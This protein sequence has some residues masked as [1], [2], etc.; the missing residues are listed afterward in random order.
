MFA[1]KKHSSLRRLNTPDVFTGRPRSAGFTLIE[2]LVVIAIIA[3]L[4]AML[5]PALGRAKMRA[6]EAGCLN[7]GRQLM[8][9]WLMYYQDNEEKMMRAGPSGNLPGWVGGSMD[10]AAWNHPWDLADSVDTSQLIDSKNALIA[11]YVKSVGVFKCPAD[12]YQGPNNTA[13]RLRTYSINPGVGGKYGNIGGTYNPEDP[14]NPRNYIANTTDLKVQKLDRPGAAKVWVMVCEHP[15]SINDAILQFVPGC[16]PTSF[17]WQDMPGSLHNGG[18]TL[19][20]A[21]GHAE[22]HK[23]LDARTRWPVHMTF[24]WWQSGSGNY[25]VGIPTPSVDYAW[26]EQGIPYQ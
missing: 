23:W 17:T 21:D 2:L 19:S 11:Q 8:L 20:F 25:S 13:P 3:I 15:D 4:A 10:N 26:M 5:V 18:T 1:F 12:R 22:T 24:K 6:E 7:N 14:A 9:G 16:P